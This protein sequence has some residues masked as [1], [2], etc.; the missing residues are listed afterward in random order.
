MGDPTL[1]PSRVEAMAR[2]E[3]STRI[4]SSRLWTVLVV[5]IAMLGGVRLS[6]ATWTVDTASAPV[7]ARLASRGPSNGTRFIGFT[8]GHPEVIPRS[9]KLAH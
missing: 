1:I 5:L 2:G 4:G 9:C 3:E 8:S 7:V 6:V